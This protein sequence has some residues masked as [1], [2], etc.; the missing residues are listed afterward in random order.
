MKFSEIEKV[1]TQKVSEYL[2][3]GYSISTATMR[4]IEREYSKIDLRKGDDLVRIM[5]VRDYKTRT[6]RGVENFDFESV[7]WFPYYVSIVVSR[8][9]LEAFEVKEFQYD[10]THIFWNSDFEVVEELKFTEISKTGIFLNVKMFRKS[11]E[12]MVLV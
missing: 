7:N 5:I 11:T 8:M 1:Y 9:D 6:W 4:G 2:A 3:K 12:S 10:E